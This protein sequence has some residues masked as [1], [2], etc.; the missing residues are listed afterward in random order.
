MPSVAS[1]DPFWSV[2]LRSLRELTRLAVAALVLAVGLGAVA[3]PAPAPSVTGPAAVTAAVPAADARLGLPRREPV[4]EQVSGAAA[5][6]AP[7]SATAPADTSA[8]PVARSDGPARDPGRGDP[9]RRGPP[10]A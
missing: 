4:A 7:R 6:P 2:T 1:V 8:A 10:G 3:A 5:A 9:A